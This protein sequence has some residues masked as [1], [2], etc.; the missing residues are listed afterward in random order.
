M[1]ASGFCDFLMALGISLG[2]CNAPPPEEAIVMPEEDRQAWEFKEPEPAP[3]PEPP[4]P[5]PRADFKPII[6]EKTIVKEIIKPAPTPEPQGPSEEELAAAR[7]R[8]QIRTAMQ[9]SFNTR[10]ANYSGQVRIPATATMQIMGNGVETPKQPKSSLTPAASFSSNASRLLDEKYDTE[11]VTSTLPVDNSRIVAADR[12][13]NVALE[14]GINTQLDG[15]EGGPVILQ[16]IRDVYGYHGYNKLIP[17]GSRM[18]C[19]YKS[20]D[21]IGESRAFLRCSRILLGKHRAEIIGIKA[22]ATD[23]QGRLG[24]TGEVDNRFSE[25]YGTAF[26]LAGISATVRGATSSLNQSES[27]ANSDSSI[28]T[29]GEELSQRLGEIS[30]AALERTINLN[31][32]LTMAQGS[33]FVIRPDTDIYI[34]KVEK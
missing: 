13:I 31:P 15:T 9:S 26:V 8:E 2:S 3:K 11:G 28:T 18:I 5:A 4:K 19:A 21:A 32:I 23:A 29:S 16:V 14:T 1:S 7:R 17:K 22:N 12:Y 30:A 6:I 24:V 34:Q 25:R 10:T 20:P 27:D 33:R